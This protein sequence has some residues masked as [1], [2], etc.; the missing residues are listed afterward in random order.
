MKTKL[1]GSAA[2]LLTLCLSS[3]AITAVKAGSPLHTE[4]AYVRAVPPMQTVSAAFM[5]VRNT[6]A[7]SR[8][9]V[10]AES[11]AADITELHTHTMKDGMMRMRPIE[12]IA[13]PA[14]QDVQLKPG[15]LHIML[16]GLKQKLVPGENVAVTLVLD[17]G[18]KTTVNATVK[19]LAMKMQH[20]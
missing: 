4:N 15:G 16:I 14:G 3:L 12:K 10:G 8:D 19:K 2:L 9:I 1:S 7:N 5:T 18:S 13:L 11:P 6:T 20:Q 17:D